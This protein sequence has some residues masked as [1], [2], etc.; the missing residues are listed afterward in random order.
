MIFCSVDAVGGELANKHDATHSHLPYTHSLFNV[1]G[2]DAFTKANDKLGY[3]FYVNNILVLFVC[4]L[5]SLCSA[6]RVHSFGRC[7]G[8]RV[9]GNNLGAASDLKYVFLSETLLVCGNIP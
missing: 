3:L 8:C 2:R 9:N 1:G 7:L 5:L 6:E 4:S